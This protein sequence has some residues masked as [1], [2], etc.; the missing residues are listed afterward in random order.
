MYK[1]VRTKNSASIFWPMVSVAFINTCLWVAYGI[2]VKD[3][4]VWLPNGLGC[5]LSVLNLTLCV[6]YPRTPTPSSAGE[7]NQSTQ[8]E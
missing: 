2:A 3:I 1:V 4:F 5:G 6:I 8:M 7:S